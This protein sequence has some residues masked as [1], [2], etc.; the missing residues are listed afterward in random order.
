VWQDVF[1]ESEHAPLDRP[2]TPDGNE[3]WSGCGRG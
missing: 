1:A 3:Q 2:G